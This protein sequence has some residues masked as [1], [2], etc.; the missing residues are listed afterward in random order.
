MGHL[1]TLVNDELARAIRHE[2]AAA[3]DGMGGKN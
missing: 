2:S 1:T 3:I